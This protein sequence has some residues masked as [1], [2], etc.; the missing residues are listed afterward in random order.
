MLHKTFISFSADGWGCV[1]FL[2]VVWPEAVQYW[3]PWAVL[4]GKCVAAWR[5]HANEYFPE[6]LPPV[7][8]SSQ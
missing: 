6:L 8:L 2:L 5:A 1:P 4:W 7:Y 3:S